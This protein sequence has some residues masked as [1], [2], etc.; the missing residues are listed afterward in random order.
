MMGKYDKAS[1][2]RSS[3]PLAVA[4]HPEDDSIVVNRSTRPIGI[5]DSGVGGLTVLAE[6]KEALPHENII[7]VGDT[8]NAPYGGKSPEALLKHGRDI[9]RFLRSHDVKAVVLACGTTSSTVYDQL[10]KENPDIP[11]VDVI[12]PGA[13]ACAELDLAWQSPSPLLKEDKN[14]IAFPVLAKSSKSDLS[15]TSHK[16]DDEA[17]PLRLGIIATA[18][19]I[20]SGLFAQLVKNQRPDIKLLTQACPLFAPMV[21]AGATHTP[22]AKW[23]AETYIGHWRGKIDALVLGCTHYPLL[24][25]A[26]SHALGKDMQY[27]NLATHTAQA[28]KARLAAIGG[29]NHGDALAHY[30]FYVSGEPDVFNKTAQFLLDDNPNAQKF[31]I[32]KP[33]K[34]A[35]VIQ[36][37]NG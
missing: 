1:S 36:S 31:P 35:H 27:I 11:L 5:F 33:S 3:L 19:T 26:L 4:T 20:K 13:K 30:K 7:Y 12:R 15:I 34:N 29:L 6:V 21:E 17:T 9:I 28:L 10:A 23:A 25:D 14:S 16:K 24:T 8:A 37:S 22:I 18:A 32:R 2:M